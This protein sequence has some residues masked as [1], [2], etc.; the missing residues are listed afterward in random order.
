LT[1]NTCQAIADGHFN[2]PTDGGYPDGG[3]PD[4]GLL[5]G[6]HTGGG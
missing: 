2:V 4:G 3:H 6:G 5:D 1:T